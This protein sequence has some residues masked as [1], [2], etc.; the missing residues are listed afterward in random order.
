[1]SGAR[2]IPVIDLQ[3]GRVVRAAGGRRSEYRPLVT[4]LTDDPTP[5]RLAGIFVQRF[6][7]RDIY[8]ADL[9]AIAGRG[10]NVAA[11]REVAA[12]GARLWL[13]ASVASVEEGRGVL[14]ELGSLPPI[15]IVGLET[16]RDP[17][18][19][20]RIAAALGPQKVAFSL[21]L[22]AGRPL[23]SI[24]TWQDL[25]PESVAAHA[26]AAGF[27]RLIL[28]DLARVGAGQGS[29]T[30][31]LCRELRA[32]Y[33]RIELVTG[34]GI[35]GRADVEQAERDGANGVLVASALHDGRLW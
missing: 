17:S 24:P 16:L 9:D 32:R 8:L 14:A 30:G 12:A 26:V 4:R 27:T 3:D 13:D 18:E 28:L 34:G 22:K 31:E 20:A 35:A 5:A 25:R 11:W 23:A 2:L 33:P 6:G 7:A 10:P 29:G 15:V 1:M 21:D 19:L